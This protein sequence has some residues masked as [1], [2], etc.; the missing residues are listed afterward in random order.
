MCKILR[1]QLELGSGSMEPRGDCCTIRRQVL[2]RL[3]RPFYRNLF[4]LSSKRRLSAIS[5]YRRFLRT[6][7][8][9]I[10]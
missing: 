10:P 5:R 4:I 6:R 9:V 3:P 8:L 7:D 1:R 2:F